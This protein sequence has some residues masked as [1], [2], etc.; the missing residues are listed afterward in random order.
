[1]SESGKRVAPPFPKRQTGKYVPSLIRRDINWGE[2]DPYNHVNN[3][4]IL[5]WMESSWASFLGDSGFSNL[6]SLDSDLNFIL[7]KVE[8]NFSKQLQYPGS[9]I[10]TCKIAELSR[11]FVTFDHYIWSIE[12]KN[13]CAHGRS[14]VVLFDRNESRIKRIKASM[15]NQ[16]YEY[17]KNVK[18][19][20]EEFL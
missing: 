15:K 18:L 14:T 20:V 17:Q 12:K 3:S 7:T 2:Q 5:R 11:S 9:I 10:A 8:C 6:I 13:I 19:N 16:L 1:M 4:I